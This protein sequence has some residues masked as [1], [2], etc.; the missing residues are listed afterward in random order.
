MIEDI[1]G[2]TSK[3]IGVALDAMLVR[4]ATI[5]HNIANADTPG[6]APVR[7]AFEEYL[8]G[9]VGESG[10][11]ADDALSGQLESVRQALDDGSLVS[12]STGGTVELDLEMVELTTNTLRYQALLT[13]AGKRGEI[14]AMAIRGGRR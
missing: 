12:K 8:A 5:A 10:D 4:H 13:A 7:V 6:Y 11:L 9:Y 2:V 1:G 14:M 3:L